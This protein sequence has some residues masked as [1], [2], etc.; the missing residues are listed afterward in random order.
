MGDRAANLRAARLR[1]AD[2]GGVSIVAESPI[3]DTDPVDVAPGFRRLRFLNQ[4][5]LLDTDCDPHDLHAWLCEIETVLGREPCA[6]ANSPR[7]ID[8][9]I[10]YAGTRIIDSPALTLPHPRWAGR[11]FVVQPLADLR[12]QLMLPGA[13]ATVREILDALPKDITVARVDF[14]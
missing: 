4:V 9:D 2:L 14:S 12:P 7:V 5:L 3:Y 10:I 11:R 6:H 13:D 8:I 1:I